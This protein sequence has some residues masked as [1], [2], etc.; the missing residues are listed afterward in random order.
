MLA[1]ELLRNV[2]G[3]LIVHVI[4]EENTDFGVVELAFS[5]SR[6]AKAGTGPLGRIAVDHAASEIMGLLA[7]LGPEKCPAKRRLILL[8]Y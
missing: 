7:R 2:K 3:W 4:A 8:H 6:T 1:E 5:A